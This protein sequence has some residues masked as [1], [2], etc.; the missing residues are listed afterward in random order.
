[1]SGRCPLPVRAHRAD[2]R[3]TP[4]RRTHPHA[5]RKDSQRRQMLAVPLPSRRPAWHGP[6][7][8]RDMK[9]AQLRRIPEAVTD[10]VRMRGTE[11]QDKPL[12]SPVVRWTRQRIAL[13]GTG[14]ALLVLLFGWLIHAWLSTGQVISHERLRVATVSRGHFVR[15]V[16]ADGTVVAAV[17]PTL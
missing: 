16:A 13:A 15:D 3:S 8:H 10:A 6:C 7:T 12:D 1:M 14:A 17:S 2:T 9:L 4:R 5:S 11:A